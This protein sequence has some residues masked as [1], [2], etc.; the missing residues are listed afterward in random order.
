MVQL[1]IEVLAFGFYLSQAGIGKSRLQLLHDQ[2]HA[3]AVGRVLHGGQGAL[4][5]IQHRQQAFGHGCR[6]PAG[7]LFVVGAAAAAEIVEIRLQAQEPGVQLLL[8]FRQLGLLGFQLL[9]LPHIVFQAEFG[10]FGPFRRSLRSRFFR[11]FG[12]FRRGGQ[13]FFVFPHFGVLQ[14]FFRVFAHFAP[15]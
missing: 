14:I 10:L 11:G 15:R 8:F 7:S 6:G 13:L 4:E 9:V 3:F 2:L 12:F 5:I 1:G